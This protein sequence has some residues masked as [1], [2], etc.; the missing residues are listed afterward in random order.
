MT[1]ID[2]KYSIGIDT[3]DAQHAK[4]I[5]LIEEFRSAGAGHLLDR[6]GVEAAKLALEQLL[7]YTCTH[8]VSEEKL[9]AE[10]KYPGLAA[11]KQ[12]HQELE[13][14]VIKL[15]DEINAH[16]TKVTPLKLNL[17]I[18]VWLMEHIIQEDDKY[19]RFI[20]GKPPRT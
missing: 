12:R 13:A 6:I 10:Y 17:F 4:W 9:L 11:H 3:M 14:A 8:F 15:L 7:A 19:A 18:T 5:Q 16:K 1:I 20:L 2:P